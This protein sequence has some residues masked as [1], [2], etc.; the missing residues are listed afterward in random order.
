MSETF[1]LTIIGG[2][3]FPIIGFVGYHF[4]S[5]MEATDKKVDTVDEK[6]NGVVKN[7]LDRFQEIRDELHEIAVENK[8]N[9]SDIMDHV[10]FI[11]TRL[12]ENMYQ[13]K[14]Q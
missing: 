6:V 4:I 12:N 5:R 10:H 14:E 13:N 3:L 7:Y 8:Q 2:G 11:R 9:H 1:Y